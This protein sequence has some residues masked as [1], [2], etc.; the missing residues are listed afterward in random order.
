[1]SSA[2][3]STVSGIV[4][5]A[6]ASRRFAGEMPKQLLEIEGEPLVRRAVAR[7]LEARF[8]EVIAVVGHRADAVRAALDGL[9]ARIV[10]NR[11]FAE[12]QS[13]SVVTGLRSVDPTACA[14][15]FMPCDQPFLTGAVLDTLIAAY[16]RTSGPI[17]VPAFEGRRGAPVTFARSLFAELE[18]IGGDV[19]GRSILPR[20]EHE[21]V[22]VEL[23][24]GRPLLDINT[25]EDYDKLTA[26]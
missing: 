22:A 9:P 12:G 25:P 13:T 6:G 21:I 17:V 3:P 26:T 18:T 16:E 15:M 11:A 14:A 1:M 10:E 24:G 19:G 5:A 7:A 8:L 23:D 20:H 2:S 4:L